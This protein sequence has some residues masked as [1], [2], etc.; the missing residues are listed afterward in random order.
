MLKLHMNLCVLH[1]PPP[2]PCSSFLFI[3]CTFFVLLTNSLILPEKLTTLRNDEF[4]DIAHLVLL[5]TIGQLI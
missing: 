1:R 2:I 5:L 4:G 3:T